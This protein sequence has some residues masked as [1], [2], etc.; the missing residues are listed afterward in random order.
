MDSIGEAGS[1]D[2]RDGRAEEF[3]QINRPEKW[4]GKKEGG[5]TGNAEEKRTG[6]VPIVLKQRSPE[7]AQDARTGQEK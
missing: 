6:I 1:T 3:I 2:K 5:A 7:P 4:T